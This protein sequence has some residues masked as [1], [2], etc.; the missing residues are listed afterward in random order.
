MLEAIGK[1]WDDNLTFREQQCVL[2]FGGMDSTEAAIV[3]RRQ[4]SQLTKD[5]RVTAAF[6]MRRI[7]E[8]AAECSRALI[9]DADAAA[10]ADAVGRALDDSLE[11]RREARSQTARSKRI[12]RKGRSQL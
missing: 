12:T 2:E 8:L 6:G 4:W 10:A 1:S 5:E 3:S 7:V 9:A 11:R